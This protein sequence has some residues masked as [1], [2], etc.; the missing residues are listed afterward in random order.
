MDEWTEFR[1]NDKRHD[2]QLAKHA[3]AIAEIQE[4]ARSHD[5]DIRRL[6][7]IAERHDEIIGTLRAV[8][9]S[10]ATKDDIL[11]LRTDINSQHAQSL[12]DAHNSIP[13]KIGIVV[14][15][16]L[17]LIALVGLVINMHHA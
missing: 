16:G 5:D 1:E 11:N 15:V 17:F 10:L 7:S 2:A 14:S 9:G 13:G 4:R 3:T 6:E 8:T 12:R